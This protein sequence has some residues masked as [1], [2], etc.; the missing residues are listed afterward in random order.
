LERLARNII[1][2]PR[3]E[4]IAESHPVMLSMNIVQMKKKPPDLL[5]ESKDATVNMTL[6]FIVRLD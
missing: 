2:R 3:A 5:S 1:H 6:F 4:T